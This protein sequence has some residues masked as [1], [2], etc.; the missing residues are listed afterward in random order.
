MVA[1]ETLVSTEI[2]YFVGRRTSLLKL[3][4]WFSFVKSV[5][6]SLSVLSSTSV[7]TTL[8]AKR[9]PALVGYSF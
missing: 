5:Y 2:T 3:N 4:F 9:N 6:S 1:M 7:N 8:Q